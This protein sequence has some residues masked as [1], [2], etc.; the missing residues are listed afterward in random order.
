M[1]SQSKL[2]KSKKIGIDCRM[3]DETGI[4]RYIRNI[5]ENIISSD[6]SN[7]YTLFCLPNNKI[8]NLPKNFKIVYCNI[9]WHT[10][11]EQFV[12]PFIFLKENLDILFVPNSNFPIL[13]FRKFVITIHDLTVLR[14]RTGRATTLPMPLYYIKHLAFR[15]VLLV[16]ILRSTKIF[17]VTEFVKKDI[18]KNFKV[19]DSK[20]LITSNAVDSKFYRRDK[21]EIEIVKKKYNLPDRYLLYV[22]NAHPHKNLETLIKAFDL[23]ANENDYIDLVLVGKS[24]FFYKRL[25]E[26]SKILNSFTRIHFVGFVED[27]DLPAVYSGA[28]LFISASKMEGFG[29][30]L[31][32]AFSC[33]TK[34]VCS[35]TSGFLEVGQDAVYYID[36]NDPDDIKSKIH[37][38]I[39]NNS[40]DKLNKGLE[41]SKQYS[42]ENSTKIILSEFKNI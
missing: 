1:T 10:F 15:L 39:D 14:E 20:I 5:V 12:L 4:G 13:Y 25:K 38:C 27:S 9:L 34:V 17:T 21:N 41:I 3:W 42:W 26:E 31:L 18:I 11:S 22:G 35:K 28:E 37:E 8:K 2:S 29:I 32:E 33:R 16:G 7:Q 6:E 30:M 40:E 36:P 23:F 24:N 19:S